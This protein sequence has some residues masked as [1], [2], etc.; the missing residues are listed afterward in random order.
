MMTSKQCFTQAQ[1]RAHRRRLGGAVWRTIWRKGNSE[2]IARKRS[3]RRLTRT[4][5]KPLYRPRR[6]L[7]RGFRQNQ[8]GPPP[9]TAQA[10]QPRRSCGNRSRRRN[11]RNRWANSGSFA[12]FCHQNS[13]RAPGSVIYL[14]TYRN[15]EL[16]PIKLTLR[17]LQLRTQIWDA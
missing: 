1:R 6:G 10:R 2:A 7:R 14:T 12:R 3:R 13:N 11:H 9:A 16:L 5:Q 8:Q 4:S 15:G 17:I